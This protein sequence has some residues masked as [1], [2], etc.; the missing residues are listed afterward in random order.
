MKGITPRPRRSIA[1]VCQTFYLYESEISI[2]QGTVCHTVSFDELASG[3][4]VTPYHSS[5][6]MNIVREQIDSDAP[7]CGDDIQAI[8]L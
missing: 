3:S 7:F 6:I 8:G 5:T 1:L 4:S 2:I